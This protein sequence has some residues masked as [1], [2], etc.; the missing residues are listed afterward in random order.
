MH[1]LGKILE[2]IILSILS[3]DRERIRQKQLVRLVEQEKSHGI[4]KVLAEQGM[5]LCVVPR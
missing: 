5:E 2:I 4:K 3:D 1:V